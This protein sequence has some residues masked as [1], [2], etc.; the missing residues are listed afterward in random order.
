MKN[1]LWQY[2]KQLQQELS[3]ILNYWIQHVPD[4]QYGGFYGCI[5]NNNHPQ[6]EAPKG[7]VLNARILW[8]FAAAYNQTDEDKYLVVA[9]RAYHYIL[10]YFVD[11]EYGGVYW[12]VNHKGEKLNDRKQIY[13]LAF[14]IYALSEYFK[15]SGAEDALDLAIK[16]YWLIEVHAFDK[17]QKGYY[18]AFSRDW[19]P[20]QDLRLSEKDANEKKTMN[21]HLHIVEAYANLYKVWPDKRLKEQIEN[22][23]EVFA[24]HIVDDETHH[25][26]LFFDENWNSKSGIISYGHD[27]EAAWLL[28]EVAE[29]IHHPGWMI[30]MRSLAVKIANA[31]SEGLDNDGG[32]NY[33]SENGHTIDQKHWWPQAEAMIGFFNA[34]EVTGD[35]AYLERSLRSWQFTNQYIKDHKNGEWFWGVFADHS[36]M[37]GHDK[38]GLWKCPYHNTRACLE[39]IG[40]IEPIYDLN[41]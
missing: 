10:D 11:E 1:H 16:L 18:E 7:V 26:N 30:T 28:Q 35:E 3:E 33:E 12:T 36:L 8:S 39:L 9:S 37:T 14:C 32:L 38:A 4:A 20:I 23:L 41:D 25:L 31:A 13:G 15:A 40:R 17:K 6:P 2:K 27:I 34:Y 19:K 22:L 24:H 5:D 29:S 21:T